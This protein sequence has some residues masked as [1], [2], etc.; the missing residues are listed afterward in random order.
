MIRLLLEVLPRI[1]VAVLLF[2]VANTFIN[3]MDLNILGNI[4][5]S[6]VE[7]IS[8][9]VS[10][11][12]SIVL[13]V[14]PTSFI[15]VLALVSYSVAT[16]LRVSMITPEALLSI[17]AIAI[18]DH[19]KSFYRNRQERFIEIG[20]RKTIASTFV[21][22]IAVIAIIIAASLLAN[23]YILSI[24]PQ[25]IA[26][27]TSN[28]F[29][30]EIVVNPIFVLS[31]SL[32]IGVAIY[33]VATALP[34]VIAIYVGG[35]RE[36][37][38]K[39]LKSRRDVDVYIGTPLT[40][41]KSLALSALFTPPAYELVSMLILPLQQSSIY[42]NLVRGAVAT[43]LFT[44]MG[45]AMYRLEKPIVLDLKTLLVLSIVTLL[46]IYVGGVILSYN[47]YRDVLNALTKPAIGYFMEGISNIYTGFYSDILIF[48][49]GV[50]KLFGVAP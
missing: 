31:F 14:Y 45:Y 26:Q 16:R 38:L 1:I 3:T 34:E 48:L 25:N 33:R 7:T 8:L 24:L 2:S 18:M 13:L 4:M 50:S 35:S 22:V 17:G 46:F 11:V 28:S 49:D 37:A 20:G 19:L 6:P 40:I 29:V 47:M 9:M 36:V 44:V 12:L 43:I 21:P 32:A 42:A 27:K 23:A 39:I 41:V 5:R 30:R 10:L 15:Y